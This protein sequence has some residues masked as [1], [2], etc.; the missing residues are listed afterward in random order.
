MDTIYLNLI[1]NNIK[2]TLF[3]ISFRVDN[4]RVRRLTIIQL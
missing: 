3:V 4:G 2:I 1:I